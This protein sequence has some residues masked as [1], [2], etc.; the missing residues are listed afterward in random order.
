MLQQQQQRQL[1][2]FKIGTYI[3]SEKKYGM[4]SLIHVVNFE[5]IKKWIFTVSSK[6]QKAYS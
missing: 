2:F 4:C 6:I 5:C 1:T 3:F